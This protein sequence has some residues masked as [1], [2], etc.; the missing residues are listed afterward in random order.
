MVLRCVGIAIPSQLIRQPRYSVPSSRPVVVLMAA[1][2]PWSQLVVQYLTRSG[3]SIHVVDFN[4]SPGTNQEL[5]AKSIAALRMKVASVHVIPPPRA[6]AWCLLV[7]AWKLR[8]LARACDAQMVLALYGGM[9]AAIACLSG[10]RP[11]GV[12]VVGSDVLLAGPL[13]RFVSRVSL[14]R[15]STVLANGRYL[16]DK[17]REVAPDVRIEPL[18]F[19]IDL[20]RFRPPPLP[21]RGHRFVCSRAFNEVYDNGTIVRA[22]TALKV[23]PPDFALSFLSSGPLL[24]ETIELADRILT[25]ATRQG[26][27]FAGGV[28]DMEVV[29]A[30]R[31][32]TFY[33]SAS[34]SDGASASLLEAMACGLVPIVSDIPANR[35]WITDRENGLLFTPGDHLALARCIE[36][37][38]EGG[39]WIAS[40]IETNYR[41]VAERANADV[42]LKR[43]SQVILRDSARHS[44]VGAH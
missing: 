35:E 38:M 16:A 11:Y 40:A 42:N 22:L 36:V 24:R 12:Y 5:A 27:S 1:S 32:A 25:A 14:R 33:L 44:T 15:A 8:A 43:L 3:F 2:S 18:Y 6:F 4:S 7:G 31:S 13:R 37:A 23:V 28:S 30:L 19:G 21:N 29:A 41:M 9:Q 39:P 10:V 26:V 17:T 20:D 34:H